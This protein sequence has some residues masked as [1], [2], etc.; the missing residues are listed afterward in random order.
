MY[1]QPIQ[2]DTLVV[3]QFLHHHLRGRTTSP[4][5]HKVTPLYCI[6][7]GFPPW[8]QELPTIENK[9]NGDV[10]QGLDAC[11]RFFESE[12][13]E[14]DLLR[15]VLAFKDENPGYRIGGL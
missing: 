13:G 14:R 11:V 7:R 12:T 3:V 15:R 4:D 2:T 1:N 10:H 9:K 5:G 6:E 8:V